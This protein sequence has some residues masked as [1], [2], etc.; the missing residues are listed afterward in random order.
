MQRSRR[1]WNAVALVLLCLVVGGVAAIGAVAGDRERIVNDFTIAVIQPDGSARISEVIDYDFGAASQRHGIYRT[2]PGLDPDTA[3]IVVESPD[4]PAQWIVDTRGI[5][6]GDPNRTING[7]HRYR[8]EYTLDGVAPGGRLAWNAVGTE[9]QVGIEH[10]EVHIVAPW[11]FTA[12]RCDRGN[13]GDTGGCTA[14]EVAP[15][16]LVMTTGSLADHRGVTVYAAPAARVTRVASAP[17]APAPPKD[18]SA[19]IVKSAALAFIAALL[20]AFVTRYFMRRAGREEVLA[21]GAADA[22]F[23]SGDRPPPPPPSTGTAMP[24]GASLSPSPPPPPPPATT[25]AVPGG[26]VVHMDV[27]DLAALATVEFAPPPD[28]TPPEGGMLLQERVR[29]EHKLAW[30]VDQAA[31]G[32]VDLDA[33][34]KKHQTLRWRGGYGATGNPVL[35]A[36]FEGRPEIALGKYDKAFARGWTLLGGQLEAWRRSSPLWSRTADRRRVRVLTIGIL[37]AIV[38]TAG[39]FVGA[40]LTGRSGPG[41][42]ALVGG[43]ALVAGMAL[44]MALCAW[45]L[46]QR[47]VRGSA[48]WLR[49]ESFRRFIAQSEAR[50]AD[51][52]AQNGILRQYTAWAIALGEIDRW[53]RAVKASTI[54]QST[55]PTAFYLATISPS[56]AHATS[57]AATAPSSSGGGGGAG[58]G[59]GGGGGGSW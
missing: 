31:H 16:H 46:R 11:R 27:D 17:E 39:V 20:T 41:F 3:N 26:A 50:H 43:A 51:W 19:G 15:G 58:G 37:L 57:A 7:R 48:L 25:P 8:I 21:G 33:A 9:W 42:L 59:A 34:D 55:D 13:P 22:A 10:V 36:M 1:R 45:E 4:A 52:A 29:D 49:V 5:R 23:A 6:I 24:T 28:L 56:L 47:T 44:A 14:N 30:L 53:S 35:L 2:I 54:A 38:A 12:I 32:A 40:L 18:D